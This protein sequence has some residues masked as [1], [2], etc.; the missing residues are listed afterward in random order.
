MN[1]EEEYSRCTAWNKEEQCNLCGTK[2][3]LVKFKKNKKQEEEE[4]EYYDRETADIPGFWVYDRT[5]NGCNHLWS[6]TR[7]KPERKGIE[8]KK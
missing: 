2:R 5:Q 3:K 6:D 7:N 8:R 4:K 1:N